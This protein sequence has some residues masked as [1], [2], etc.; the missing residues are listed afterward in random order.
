MDDRVKQII[1]LAQPPARSFLPGLLAG[2]LSAGAA[3]ALLASSA[4]LI[5]K[6]AEQ[7]S[8]VELGVAVVGVRAFALA[9]ASF[10]YLERLLSHDAA[11]R[12]LSQLRAGM[13]ERVIPVAPD[14]LQLTGRG[15]LLTRLVTDV[16]ELQNVPLRVVQP[17]VVSG[18]IA[19]AAVILTTALLPAAGIALA[20]CLIVA[21]LVSWL[22]VS[23]VA[24]RAERDLAPLRG[25]L[26]EALLDLVTGLDV[27]TAYGAVG[28]ARAR[29]ERADAAL[30]RAMVRRAAGAGVAGAV[31]ALAS[32]SAVVAALWAGMPALGAIG[33]PALTVVVLVPLAVFEVCSMVPLAFGAWREAVAS[34]ERVADAVPSTR[35]AEIPD[36]GAGVAELPV[37]DGVLLEV[38]HLSARWPGDARPALAPISFRLSAGDRL[39]VEGDSGAG[40]T[41][42]AHVLVRFLEYEGR[43]RVGGVEAREIRADTL[44]ETVG[45]V[46]QR[47]FL[48][49]ADIRQNLLFARDTADDAALEAVLERVGLSSWLAERGGLDR[50]VGE[51]GALVSGGQAQRIALA[52]ALLREFPVLVLD[53]PTANVDPE[54]ANAL[55]EDLLGAAGSDGRA[56]I[57]ISHTPV[58]AA[59]VT[60]RLRIVAPPLATFG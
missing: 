21:F 54:R 8:I 52:R 56:V 34:A 15:D 17:L 43:Y 3:V 58:P 60:D 20:V 38:E 5:T 32:G 11:F 55:L 57:V 19:G 24:A 42:L 45:L 41:T 48:F 25:A 53:E 14:G 23:R 10:R 27:L 28:A 39:L 29:I 1:R 2:I 18:V 44:R 13:I 46:E 51:H 49:D 22:L 50:P 47:P 33:G 26:S 6:A 12:Q 4:F 7:P 37:S 16:D 35:P 36:E 59:L 9:R 30:T 40:K 31:L